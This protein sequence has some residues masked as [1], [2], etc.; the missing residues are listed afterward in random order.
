MV[1]EVW[2]NQHHKAASITSWI[3]RSEPTASWPD[4]WV[5]SAIFRAIP[6]SPYDQRLFFF[7]WRQISS[8][9]LPQLCSSARPP[10]GSLI[11]L[12]HMKLWDKIRSFRGICVSKSI[13]EKLLSFKLWQNR[14]YSQGS[15][16]NTKQVSQIIG[17]WP[18]NLGSG[19][20]LRTLKRRT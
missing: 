7:F 1:L 16:H 19:H 11:V 13:E 15:F 20:I 4:A 6:G 18:H 12:N 9:T 8:S 3:I 14:I 2:V 10:L 5:Y 17:F